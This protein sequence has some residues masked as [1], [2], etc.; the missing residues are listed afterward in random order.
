MR[1]VL[2]S[3]SQYRRELLHRLGLQFVVDRPDIDESPL[4][5]E[6]AHELAGRLARAKAQAVAAR[7]PNALVVGSD[8]V[9]LHEATILSKPGTPAAAVA[10]LM[11]IRGKTTVF[12]T[13]LCLL[14][15]RTGRLQ[16]AVVPFSVTIRD[17]SQAAVERYVARD[18]PYDCVG[19][20]KAEGLGI[21]LFSRMTGDDPTALIGL[22]L[23]QLV[24]MLNAEGVDVV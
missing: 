12:H 14:N 22:P 23:I 9:A 10:Q 1:I 11:S 13:G 2:A 16:S 24:T 18:Q 5:A 6:S 20:F 3:S 8:Q 21:A 7:H 15:T 19:A 17:L 4:A